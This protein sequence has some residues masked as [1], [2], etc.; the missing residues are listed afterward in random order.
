MSGR[1]FVSPKG[2]GPGGPNPRGSSYLEPRTQTAAVNAAR[3][4]LRRVGGGELTVQRPNGQI[5][6]ATPCRPSRTGSRRAGRRSG[7]D[8]VRLA[9]VT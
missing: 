9:P 7:P 4:Q 3:A 8:A 6:A 1:R 5:G 2:S